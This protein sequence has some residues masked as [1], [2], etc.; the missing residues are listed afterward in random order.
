MLKELK[1]DMENVKKKVFEQS[2]NTSMEIE[3]LKKK[4]S[5]T[6]KYNNWK[7]NFKGI[8]EQTDQSIN[9]R[10]GQWKLS[11]ERNG[12]RKNLQLWYK[13][14]TIYIVEVSKGE[15]EKGRDYLK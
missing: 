4:N 11:S 1:E 6:K 5:R 15:R 13:K 2:G 12:K 9:W 3:N 8:F 7:E 14:T 10:I